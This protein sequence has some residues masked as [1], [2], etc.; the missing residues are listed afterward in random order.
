MDIVKSWKRSQS[1]IADFCHVLDCVRRE[2]IYIFQIRCS[3]LFVRICYISQG[4]IIQLITLFLSGILKLL[5]GNRVSYGRDH[6]H[7]ILF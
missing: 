2:A 6:M 7:V 5:N 4:K 1:Q 3:E